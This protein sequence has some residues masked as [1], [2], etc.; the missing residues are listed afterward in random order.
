MAPLADRS[1]TLADYSVDLAHSQTSSDTMFQSVMP[2]VS[3][4]EA[5]SSFL[6][7]A[8][9]IYATNVTWVAPSRNVRVVGRDA[10]IRQQVRE[11]GGMRDPEF[12]SLRRNGN[13]RQIIDEFSVR[14]VYAGDGIVNAPI[15][16]GDFIELK[17][18]RILEVHAGRVSYETC[19]E[20]W[21]V[22]QPA[23]RPAL[24]PPL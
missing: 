19:I 20:N 18:V 16:C 12:T 15:E 17:R 7:T 11:V 3:V 21:T 1:A 9:D 8:R 14:F 10:V 22:L 2:A 13:P 24:I 23:T 6:T 5:H 4:L